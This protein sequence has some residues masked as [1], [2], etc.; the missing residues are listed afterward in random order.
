[1]TIQ[2]NPSSPVEVVQTLELKKE[3]LVSTARKMKISELQ[4]ELKKIHDLALQGMKE[5]GPEVDLENIKCFDVPK[6]SSNFKELRKLNDKSNVYSAVVTEKFD[7]EQVKRAIIQNVIEATDGNLK[8]ED[9]NVDLPGESPYAVRGLGDMFVESKSYRK[10]LDMSNNS[11]W[12]ER[13]VHADLQ[14]AAISALRTPNDVQLTTFDRTTGWPTEVRRS[15]LVQLSEQVPIQLLDILPIIRISESGYKYMRETT[16]TNAAASRA[17]GASFSESALAL[18]QQSLIVESIGAYISMTDEQL[19]DVLAARDYVNSRLANQVRQVADKQALLG[20]GVSPNVQGLYNNTNL[21]SQAKTSAISILDVYLHA[22]T[23]I[24]KN[25]YTLP[26]SVLVS[27]D[28]YQRLM[29]AKDS[30]GRYLFG[31]PFQT[32]LNN[33]WGMRIIEN[34]N[35]TANT[36]FMGDFAMQSALIVREDLQVS[37]GMIN[38]QFVKNM[39]SVKAYLRMGVALFR[40]K[41]FCKLSALDT[42]DA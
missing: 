24:R 15:G 28:E 7:S 35:L 12:S 6:D 22:R 11:K 38:D 19:A 17:E 13:G 21:L 4:E 30:Q 16:Y 8:P 33:I 10:A 27:P 40:N 31:S 23:L 9:V 14:G 1:M 42:A 41:S 39:Q 26:G 25:A 29:L 5:A 20:D 37:V 3:E 18:T 36:A 2:T 34:D 32:G